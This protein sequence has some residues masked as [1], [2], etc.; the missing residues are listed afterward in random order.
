MK[1]KRSSR[2]QDPL[3][4]RQLEVLA[5]TAMGLT[6]YEIGSLLYISEETVKSHLKY[7]RLQLVARNRTHAL[8]QALKQ[9][10]L[11]ITL[12]DG[13]RFPSQ[14]SLFGPVDGWNREPEKLLRNLIQGSQ[15]P[16]P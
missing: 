7:V 14:E 6:N 8:Y 2:I 1:E 11:S 3:T 13:T 5:L 9:G 10:L 4:P 12:L 15:K 16:S